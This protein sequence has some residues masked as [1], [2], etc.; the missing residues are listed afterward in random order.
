MTPWVRISSCQGHGSNRRLPPSGRWL[1]SDLSN[2]REERSLTNGYELVAISVPRTGSGRNPSR[3]S[4]A[5]IRRARRGDAR[6]IA[7]VNVASRRWSYRGQ[8]SETELDRLSVEDAEL[9][10]AG[11]LA[12]SS[13][14]QAVF[15][16]ELDG[17]IVGY[18]AVQNGSDPDLPLGTFE[19]GGLYV[20]EDIAGT[21]AAGAL[22]DAVVRDARRNGRSVLTLWVRRDNV[23]AR[24]FYETYGFELDGGERS[25][26]H[27][28]IGVPI[29]ELRYRRLLA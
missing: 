18:S 10:V 20:I 8:V 19:L 24:R 5:V 4:E 15:V 9:I 11:M 25:G 14:T 23:R 29:H 2:G 28:V 13:P 1:Y 7:E 27:P 21:G 22:M 17:R 26:P 3:V 12:G 16:A 6:A